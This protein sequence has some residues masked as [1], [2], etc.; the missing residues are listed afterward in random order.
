MLNGDSLVSFVEMANVLLDITHRR[1]IDTLILEISDSI[2]IIATILEIT[3]VA[4]CLVLS[5]LRSEHRVVPAISIANGRR[6]A[7]MSLGKATLA[8]FKVSH[9]LERSLRACSGI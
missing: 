4:L 9:R 2:I 3:S 5:L 1:L 8:S 6:Q 7:L